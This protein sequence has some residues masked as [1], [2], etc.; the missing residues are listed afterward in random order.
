MRKATL[1]LTCLLLISST[2]WAAVTMRTD[3]SFTG[4]PA[5]A[6]DGSNTCP[7]GV[8]IS[9]ATP[10]GSYMDSGTTCGFTNTLTSY[11]G[12]CGLPFPYG[13]E[14][15]IYELPLGP[16]NLVD[17]SMDLTGSTGDLVLFLLGTCGNGTSCVTN[18]QDAIGIGAGPEVIDP[19]N[20]PAGTYYLYVDSYYDAGTT[21]SCGSYTLTVNG[22]P[23]PV[24][25]MEFT[26]D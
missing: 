20:Y 21:G 13:G 25:L 26:I 24:E 17:F 14:D 1:V 3:P 4:R 7:P 11:S 9:S 19:A 12:A 22:N 15:S 10:V 23:F 2:A 8:T 6:E 16:G 18:S 5:P